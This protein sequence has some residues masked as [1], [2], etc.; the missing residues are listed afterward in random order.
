MQNFIA[1]I[2]CD[3]LE[4]LT[5]ATRPCNSSSSRPA[6][7]IEAMPTRYSNHCCSRCCCAL[8][9]PSTC[10]A[11]PWRPLRARPSSANRGYRS[12]EKTGYA[13]QTDVAKNLL[14]DKSG[15]LPSTPPEI[16]HTEL[17]RFIFIPMFLPYEILAVCC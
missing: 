1:K 8:P 17:N 11:W 6:A 4:A 5:T 14:V 2:V 3:K 10:S 16:W 12:Q 9:P 7:S 13:A 15:R